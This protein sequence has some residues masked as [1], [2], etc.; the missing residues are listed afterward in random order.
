MPGSTR[1]QT[2][3]TQDDDR[4]NR[5]LVAHVA[6]ALGATRVL[7]L[8]V[9]AGG[10]LAVAAES[11]RADEDAP[12]LLAAITPWLVEAGRTRR[13]R[14]RH[15]PAGVARSA[16]RSCLVAPLVAG[17]KVLG[18]LYVDIDGATGRFTQQG[19]ETVGVLAGQAALARHHRRDSKQR[20]AEFAVIDSIQRSV[21]AAL[22]FQAIVDVVGDKL[23][24]VFATSDM[25]IRWWDESTGLLRTLYSY[26]HGVR[27]GEN[28]IRP[29]PGSSAHRLLMGDHEPLVFDTVAEQLAV[30]NPTQAGTDRAPSQI[31]VTMLVGERVLGAVVLENREREHAFGAADVALLQTV[32]GSMGVALLDAK[33][34]EAERQ[35]AAEHTLPLVLFTSLGH[36]DA[37]SGPFAAV[38]TKPLRQSQLFDTL[39]TLLAHDAAP[40][41]EPA[42]AARPRVDAGLAAR[43]PLRILVAEDNVVNQKLA[44]R[45]LQQM[46]YRAD[47]ASN[48]VEAIDSIARQ[49]YDVV[50]MDVQMPE[51]DG[52]EAT[53]RI[54]SRWPD[55]DRP[56]IVAMTA[57]AMQG[58][59]EA[60]LAAGMDDYVAKPIRVDALV[61]ALMAVG[62]RHVV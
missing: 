25:S 37:E 40:K 55:G 3:I 14:L 54:V 4:E 15:G 49:P 17:R 38:L 27:L 21:G 8:L 11:L 2:R 59:R 45:L 13:A 28:V 44:L 43:H 60:C 36:R 31:A 24:E 6:G 5:R 46:R 58:D 51:M 53:R 30:G 22:D 62:S 10:A 7:L 48:G 9:E 39:V 20:A 23:R 34:F 47:L 16:Q 56:R 61:E 26:E 50:L 1:T 42:P 18:H 35:R 52:L 12:A 32:A 33:S 19:L 41:S 57:N 29:V